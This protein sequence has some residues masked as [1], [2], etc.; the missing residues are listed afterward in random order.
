MDVRVIENPTLPRER[1][2]LDTVAS[3]AQKTNISM[4]EVGVFPSH[5]MNAFATG[6]NRNQSLVAVS[7]GLLQKM[8]PDETEAV[9]GH[10]VTHV[11]NGDM[12][13][14]GLLQGVV[15]TYVVYPAMLIGSVV[16]GL[17]GNERERD[18]ER[19]GEQDDER[20]GKRDGERDGKQDGEQDDERDGKQDD[21]QDS[22]RSSS[23]GILYYAVF[24]LAQAALSLLATLIVKG[25]SRRREYRA[26]AGGARLAGKSKMIAALKRLQS[27]VA[28]DLPG[29]FAA[30]GIN[31]GKPAGLIVLFMTHPPLKDRIAALERSDIP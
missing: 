27:D 28:T 11:A 10:E 20:D 4:P 5:T 24:F 31:D 18:G 8:S 23:R 29:E 14:M 7:T 17:S 12:V 22:E 9:L 13:T 21:A 25:F 6:M 15:N 26:D 3:Q 19:D 1:W 2:L 30:F 16:G